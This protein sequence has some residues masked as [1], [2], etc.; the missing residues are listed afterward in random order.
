[1]FIL[2][3]GITSIGVPTFS[4]DGLK[5]TEN[6]RTIFYLMNIGVPSAVI[7]SATAYFMKDLIK[8]KERNF[9]L[10]QITNEKNKEIEKSLNVK[11]NW[12]YLK[13]ILFQWYRM[14]SEHLLQ[15]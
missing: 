6:A 12:E 3:L 14:N 2:I 13:L 9:S 7:F 1:M 10:L 8:Q 5:V 4:M 15:P 11:R